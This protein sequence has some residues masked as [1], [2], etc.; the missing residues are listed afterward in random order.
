VLR[1]GIV[2][3]HSNSGGALQ[4]RGSR[5]GVLGISPDIPARHILFACGSSIQPI[6]CRSLGFLVWQVGRSGPLHRPLKLIGGDSRRPLRLPRPRPRQRTRLL[7]P[8]PWIGGRRSCSHTKQSS[9]C[10]RRPLPTGVRLAW[11]ST[12]AFS[13]LVGLIYSTGNSFGWNL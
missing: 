7:P 10:R 6:I 4:F 9:P 1:N 2:L 13:D 8:A 11:I 3:Q 5:P 12:G